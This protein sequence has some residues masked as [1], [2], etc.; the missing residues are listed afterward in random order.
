MVVLSGAQHVQLD[1]KYNK[2]REACFAAA[3]ALNVDML[4][5]ITY[6][7]VDLLFVSMTVYEILLILSVGIGCGFL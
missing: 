2:L 6:V 3:K 7:R 4:R 5:D 1:G